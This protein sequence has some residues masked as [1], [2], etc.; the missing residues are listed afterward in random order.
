[1]QYDSLTSDPA[2]T[3]HAIYD[4]LGEPWFEHD[5]NHVDYDVSEF[6]ER[7]GTPGLHTVRGQ[8]KAEARETLLPPDLFN[9]FIHDAFWRDPARTPAGLRVV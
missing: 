1:V 5:F 6:D 3:L 4:F 9:R 2:R 7:A 8:V